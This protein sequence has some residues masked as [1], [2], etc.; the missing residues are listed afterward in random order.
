MKKIAITGGIGSGKSIVGKYIE[1]IGYPVFSC[2][3]IYKEIIHTPAYVAAIAEC[4]PTAIVKEKI[5]RKKISAIV[6]NDEN[7]LK[8][9]NQ[10]SHPLIMRVLD[11]RMNAQSF[12]LVFAEVPLLFEGGFENQFDHILV[13]TRN[14]EMRIRDIVQR[15]GLSVLDAE[16]RISSQFDYDGLQAQKYFQEKKVYRIE[17]DGSIFQLNEKVRGFID[18]LKRERA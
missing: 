9:L 15:D 13:I 16:K 14:K 6:F 5:D 12:D 18:R 8:K 3:E 1:T 17:N 11:E 10:I 4:F 2:D 7:A